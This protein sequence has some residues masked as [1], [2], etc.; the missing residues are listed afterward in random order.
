MDQFESDVA[1]LELQINKVCVLIQIN[2]VCVLIQINKVCVLIQTGMCIVLIDQ[3][4]DDVL[5]HHGGGG[6]SLQ[7]S[8][9]AVCFQSC[10]VDWSPGEAPD[11]GGT[12]HSTAHI[13]IL[14]RSNYCS[15]YACYC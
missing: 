9:S 5:L 2:K 6:A 8:Q 10:R 11:H 12:P 7:L 3:S 1:V 15:S 13:L 14:L 4:G